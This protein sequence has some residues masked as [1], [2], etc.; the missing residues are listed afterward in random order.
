[1]IFSLLKKILKQKI[2][3]NIALYSFF[4]AIQK[5]IPFLLYPLFARIFTQEEVGY[6]MLYQ[7]IYFLAIPIFTMSA[8]TSISINYFKLD[9]IE[10]AK[11]LTTV[12]SSITL[13]FILLVFALYFVKDLLA[14]W[15]DFSS[16]WLVIAILPILPRVIIN[17]LLSLYRNLNIPNKYGILSVCSSFLNNIIGLVLIYTTSLSWEGIIIGVLVG[18]TIISIVCIWKLNKLNYFC[19]TFVREYVVDAFKISFPLSL[20]TVGCWLSNSLNRFFITTIIGV[21]ATGSYGIG[22]TFSLILN[23]IIDSFN[24][25]FGPYLYQRLREFT[26]EDRYEIVKISCLFYLVI[27]L[28]AIIISLIGFWG[29]SLFF[30]MEYESTKDFIIPLVLASALNGGYK[31]HVNSLFFSKKTYLITAVTFSMGILNIG[32]AYWMITYYGLLGAAYSS[33]CITFC[34]YIL[35]MFLA[36]NLYPL[37]WW[38]NINLLIFNSIKND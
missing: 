19:F 4:S 27:G 36:N 5:C 3:H 35:I 14:K 23:L 7:A 20:H 15:I 18:D 32:L 2:I 31:V 10:F 28:S 9:K 17:V 1:M 22:A 8:E 37:H 30:G 34:S 13:Y 21:A 25:A 11:Y 38:K 16:F 33:V 12:L 29:V 26:S 6:Y 24:L